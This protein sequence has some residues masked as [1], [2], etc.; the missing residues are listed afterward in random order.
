MSKVK[1]AAFS[2]SMDGFGAGPNQSLQNPLGIRG[3]ELHE[4][5]FKTQVFQ[6]E[7][8]K[9]EGGLT[10]QDNAVAEKAMSGLGAWIL[11]RNMFSPTRGAWDNSWK[12]WWGENPPYHCPVYVLT[13]HA[14]P[15]LQMEGGT[16]FYFVT[17]GI[18]SALKQAKEAAQGKDIRIGGGVATIKQYL[19][20][21][22][23]DEIH[24]VFSPV[25]LGA[26]E[27]IFFG[28]D[29]PKLG[30]KV[31]ERIATEQATHIF[32]KK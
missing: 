16:T 18:H 13:H 15:P 1:V 25:F 30:F 12:G 23:I 8:L 21:N 6:R 2:V 17:D 7:V 11:G 24:F 10:N 26:G 19:Q 3:T 28:I 27:N 4:W 14:R 20:A 9:R 32:L 5:F 22:L 31:T 29:L